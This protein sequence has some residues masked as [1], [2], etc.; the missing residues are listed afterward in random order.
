MA[1]EQNPLHLLLIDDNEDDRRLAIRELERAFDA[2]AVIEIS[3]REQFE[4]H[5]AHSKFDVTITDFQLGWGTG[6][7]VLRAI[8]AKF[9]DCPV[10]MFSA[11]ASQEEAVEA[12]KSGLDDYV[13][14]SPK[15]YIRLPAAVRS[16]RERVSVL[17]AK[18][19]AES[20][21]RV[22][23]EQQKQLSDERALLLREL[24]HRVKNNLQI[25]SSLL[26]LQS[27]AIND[28]N[29]RELF[30]ISLMRVRSIS[31]VHEKLYRTE[32]LTRLSFSDYVRDLA[33]E[34]FISYGVSSE[35]IGLHVESLA[36]HGSLTFEMAVPCGL[37]VNELLS[38]AIRYAFPDG[39]RGE[40][41][42]LLKPNYNGSCTLIFSDN[43]VGLPAGL[44][45]MRVKTLGLHLVRSLARQQLR[46]TFEYRFAG[47]AEF[48]ITFP[49]KAK[50]Y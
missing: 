27:G 19:R 33:A 11:S 13:V 37:I 43:G 17:A 50:D 22:A 47:G 15:N 21:L 44:E 49:V 20:D 18:R 9:A 30:R 46:G 38:N 31:L 29:T 10:I 16:V 48:N 45:I 2:L 42:I 28:E 25:V 6:L 26:D 36:D 24:Y 3:T 8:K 7:D 12:M 4:D 40:I 34:V 41:T 32:D 1:Q 23:Y 14:K 39:R 5:L 35:S